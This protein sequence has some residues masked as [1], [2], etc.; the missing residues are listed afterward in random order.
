MPLKTITLGS[1]LAAVMNHINP[2]LP[3]HMGVQV[4]YHNR[5]LIITDPQQRT[6]E[7]LVL[8]KKAAITPIILSKKL[9]SSGHAN[10]YLS[11]VD[12]N[13]DLPKQFDNQ[14]LAEILTNK[15]NKLMGNNDIQ[16]QWNNNG[17]YL[18]INDR[19]GLQI[20]YFFTNPS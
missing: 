3:E 20:T 12:V 11:Y 17:Q 15:L 16:S 6:I 2:H 1:E 9:S 14:Q 13:L 5:Q 18:I 7:T 19:Q 10:Y 8:G 4:A